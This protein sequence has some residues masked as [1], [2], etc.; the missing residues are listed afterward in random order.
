[1][2]KVETLEGYEVPEI[3]ITKKALLWVESIVDLH[4][5][6]VGFYGSVIDEGD[7]KYI[8]DDIF[9]PKHD[10]ATAATC[11]ISSAGM[12]DVMEYLIS[13]D[14]VDDIGRL[15]MWGH[16]HVNMGVGP[17]GQDEEMGLELAK[18]NGTFLIR[19]ITNKKGIMGITFYDMVNKIRF[20]DLPISVLEAS[21]DPSHV[22]ED[23]SMIT[24]DSGMD[25]ALALAEIEYCIKTWRNGGISIDEI[26]EKVKELKLVNIPAPTHNQFNNSYGRFA[27]R[28]KIWNSNTRKWDFI[29]EQP[30]PKKTTEFG[31][32]LKDKEE[33][34]HDPLDD[35]FDDMELYKEVYG[36]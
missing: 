10:L 34:V 9:Y 5:T 14:R 32:H 23:I 33:P 13:K 31:D 21:A 1:M 18:D 29:D 22:M 6:E 15:K 24:T 27:S 16:S 8:I 19:M 20:M 11:E 7:G 28:D 12:T 30:A 25:P 2:S 17:S 4:S 3:F 36:I 26:D 35:V